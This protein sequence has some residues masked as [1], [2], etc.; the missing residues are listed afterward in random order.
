[1]SLLQSFETF[2]TKNPHIYKT[3]EKY[4]LELI[5]SGHK[6]SSAWL[7]V[8]RMRWDSAIKTESTLD[9][10]IPNDYIGVYARRFH[11]Q[12]PN[13]ANFF[14]VKKTKYDLDSHA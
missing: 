4:A 14:R 2:D 5:H 6:H 7:V 1:M 11:K 8:N 10:K 3:F 9:Y 12:H 13:H